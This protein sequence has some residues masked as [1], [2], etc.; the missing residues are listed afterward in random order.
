[1]HLH[2]QRQRRAA[3]RRRGVPVRAGRHVRPDL[4]QPQLGQRHPR[5]RPAQGRRRSPT[6]RSSRPSC[7]STATAMTAVLAAA[8][9]SARNLLAFP[10]Q[11]N[12][13]GVQHPLDLVD[14]A[15]DAGLGR[16]R[17][18]RRLRADQPVRRRPG[19]ARLRDALVLQDVR[20][21][22]RRR[23]PADAPRPASTPWS[24]R[25]S[26][27]ARSPSRRCRATATTSTAT[28]PAFEDG[29]VDYLN[30]PAVDDRPAAPRAHR[31][32][33]R[34]TTGSS[35]LT[36]W[37]LDALTGLRHANGRPV[38]ADPR[39]DRHRRA[40]AARSRS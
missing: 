37:L 9:P 19:P 23:L 20:L 25:G 10:A 4:R 21:P 13:S 3:A 31:A 12:F 6:S 15:H 14:E 32:R 33:R 11:S 35:C 18:R 38:V 2:R 1:M 28:R 7:A 29:T 36:A 16:A 30:L 22:D 26:P 39:A 40:R 17:R 8:D 27:A 34:S 5:V 24:A